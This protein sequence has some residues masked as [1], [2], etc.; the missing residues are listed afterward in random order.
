MEVLSKTDRAMEMLSVLE[1]PKHKEKEAIAGKI[2]MSVRQVYRAWKKV[3]KIREESLIYV[4]E[5]DKWKSYSLWLYKFFTEKWF[6]DPA[7]KFTKKETILLS[8]IEVD[9]Q[10]MEVSSK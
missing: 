7:K 8:K 9:L 2:G 1:N 4:I 3:K 6:P 10:E 5:L